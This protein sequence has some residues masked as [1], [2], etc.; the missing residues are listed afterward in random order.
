MNIVRKWGGRF[1]ALGPDGLR[2][3]ERSGR[4][5]SYG[6]GPDVRVAIEASTSAPPHPGMTWSHRTIAQRVA[7]TCF[8]PLS[9]SQVGRILVGLDL[10]PHKGPWLAHSQGHPRFLAASCWDV[11]SPVTV[12][13]RCG[14]ALDR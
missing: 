9:A 6:Y 11:R 5:K 4:P 8:A 12:R 13:P 14:G 2:D 3:A 7:G 10:K 1:A